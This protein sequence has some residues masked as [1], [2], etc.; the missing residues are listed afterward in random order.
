MGNTTTLTAWSPPGSSGGQY[1]DITVVP[2]GKNINAVA[3]TW[4]RRPAKT[5]RLANPGLYYLRANETN[6]DADRLWHTYVMLTD[7][8]AVFR[9]CIIG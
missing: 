5:G 8:E 9:Y 7:L 1:Y 4:K 3:L 6:W 2:D